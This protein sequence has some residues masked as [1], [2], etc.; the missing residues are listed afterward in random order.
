MQNKY[1]QIK[2]RRRRRAAVAR[3]GCAFFCS[4]VAIRV[5]SF[6]PFGEE[7]KIIV[8]SS[9]FPARWFIFTQLVFICVK[10]R[11]SLCTHCVYWLVKVGFVLAGEILRTF[12]IRHFQSRRECSHFAADSIN[13]VCVCA[14]HDYFCSKLFEHIT[15]SYSTALLGCVLV[16]QLPGICAFQIVIRAR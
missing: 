11:I 14:G 16:S 10:M 2:Q 15:S 7:Q 12:F 5:Y 13:H 1:H 6:V 9:R 8:I 3:C 4:Y